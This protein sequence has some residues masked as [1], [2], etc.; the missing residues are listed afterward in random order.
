VNDRVENIDARGIR[1]RRYAGIAMF[2][3]G[4]AA[5][6]LLVL[7]RAPH[8]WRLVL[9]LPFAAGASGFLQARERT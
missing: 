9:I 6:A 5:A 2:V 7:F 8:W 3:V 1:R 4:A